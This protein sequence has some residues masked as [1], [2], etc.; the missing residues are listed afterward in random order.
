MLI[1]KHRFSCILTNTFKRIIYL[2]N[3]KQALR[4]H[5][6]ILEFQ[7]RT[8][9]LWFFFT[10]IGFNNFKICLFSLLRTEILTIWW[11]TTVKY[12]KRSQPFSW[13]CFYIRCYLLAILRHSP[14]LMSPIRSQ[15][16]TINLI[17]QIYPLDQSRK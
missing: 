9:L 8:C 13:L 10:K 6:S 15:Y 4:F 14:S 11:L 7:K 5:F 1:L 3:L 12:M 16:I 2:I 17:R